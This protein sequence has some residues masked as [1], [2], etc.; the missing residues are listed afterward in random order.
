MDRKP[1][2]EG[3]AHICT[4]AQ[5][6][7]VDAAASETA[8]I[9]G[10]VLMENAALACVSELCARFDVENTSFAVLDVYKRQ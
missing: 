10:I 6:R 9:P 7:A 8:K 5:M 1:V 2:N 3:A 4:A